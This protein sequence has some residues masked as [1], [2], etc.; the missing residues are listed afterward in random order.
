MQSEMDP[1]SEEPDHGDGDDLYQGADVYDDCDVPLDVVLAHLALGG[2]G[3]VA[4]FSVDA[5]GGI[6]WSGDTEASDAE[7]E[8]SD[9][10]AVLRRGQR[11]KIA[12][13][14]YQGPAWEEH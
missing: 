7:P 1:T 5:N 3:V 14:R 10:P 9:E 2:S 12:V 8:E 6:T 4:N 11:R 13:R